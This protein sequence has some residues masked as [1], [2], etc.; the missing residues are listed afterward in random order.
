MLL[1]TMREGF[2]FKAS[3]LFNPPYEVAS[4]TDGTQWQLK[5]IGNCRTYVPLSSVLTNITITS[6]LVLPSYELCG[7]EPHSLLFN[8]PIY[9]RKES[10]SSFPPYCG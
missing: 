9:P 1:P 8:V 4:F 3:Y 10:N 5:D 2:T 7:I 6:S